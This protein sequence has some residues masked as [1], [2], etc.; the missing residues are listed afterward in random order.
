MKKIFNESLRIGLSISI[1]F[2]LSIAALAAEPNDTNLGA[3][4]G[5][6][7]VLDPEGNEYR[8]GNAW[9]SK[10]VVLVFI[11]HFG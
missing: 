10:P 6:S 7:V 8:L 1:L 3:A 11:R 9:E 4:I 5:A 2:I